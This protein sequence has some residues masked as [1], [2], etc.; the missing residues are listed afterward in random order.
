[1]LRSIRNLLLL[2]VCLM[3]AHAVSA[4][5]G[6]WNLAPGAFGSRHWRP[7]VVDLAALPDSGLVGEVHLIL[8]TGELYAWTG[9]EWEAVT[10]AYAPEA[11]HAASADVAD[12]ATT[13]TSL[14]NDPSACPAGEYAL[15]LSSSGTLTCSPVAFVPEAGHA[16]IAD[17]ATSAAALAT[18]PAACSAGQYV[19][20][21]A[22]TGALTCSTPP[23]VL[24]PA[25]AT[26]NAVPRFDGTSGSLIQSSA[27][28]ITDDGGI[29]TGVVS[30][31]TGSVGFQVRNTYNN[32]LGH[33]F[34]L[35]NSGVG[36]HVWTDTIGT[37]YFKVGVAWLND[38]NEKKLL[39][40][41]PTGLTLANDRPVRWSSTSSASGAPDVRLLRDAAG[42]L[43]V[44]DLLELTPLASAPACDVG[45]AGRIYHDTSPAFCWCDGTTWQKLGGA[46]NC[47]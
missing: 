26:D 46:G 3:L 28:S 24:G 19:L 23:G 41:H 2:L 34:S 33:P 30:G 9:S 16:A 22:S 40:T 15:D 14:A 1:M 21:I 5:S 13:A 6:G 35:W 11:G 4:Q 31:A 25:S 38:V 45:G 27:V 17:L 47:T 7:P 43:K 36:E 20:D 39:W 8:A 42:V 12:A 18:D 44:E 29:V 32:G 10:N 37:W